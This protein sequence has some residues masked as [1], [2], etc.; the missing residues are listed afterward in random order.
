[1]PNW[2]TNKVEAPA[3]VIRAMLN[4]EGRVDFNVIAPF[5]GPHGDWVGIYGDAETA[6]RG[7]SGE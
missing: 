1:M 4:G 3:H 5:P 6:G 7:G 2:V